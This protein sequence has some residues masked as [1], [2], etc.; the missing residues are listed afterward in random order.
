M[1]ASK[2]GKSNA[3]AL[4]DPTL[5][6]GNPIKEDLLKLNLPNHRYPLLQEELE[7][8][9]VSQPLGMLLGY[10][11]YLIQVEATDD[12]D[13][14]VDYAKLIWEDI[15][16]KLNKK[17]RE[18]VVPYPRFISLLLE[19]MMPNYENEDLT[20]NP[21]QVISVLNWALKPNQPKRPLFIDHIKAIIDMP[22][23]FQA[24]KTSSQTEKVPPS[25]KPR[26]KSGLRRNFF[27]NTHLSPRL[28]HP[29]PKLANQQAAGGPTS[30]GAT[31]EE[32]AHLQL[33]S[34]KAKSARDGT[35]WSSKR[36]KLRQKLLPLKLGPHI[37][38]S[39]SLLNSWFATVVENASGVTG[40]SVPSAGPTTASPA[41]GGEEHQ[42][43][44]KGF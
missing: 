8:T 30:L 34:D 22:M 15:I 4:D 35:S 14:S 1:R 13:L 31:S 24:P 29:N 17:T 39:T 20:V 44:Y 37:Q 23:D 5:Q 40:K 32:G 33:S 43:S 12:S 16:H 2:Y 27:Q 21:T 28:R 3:S 18:K 7:E 26:D 41:K 11:T 9:Y 6:A 10:I 42:S 38:I 19:Y 36:Q 25:K